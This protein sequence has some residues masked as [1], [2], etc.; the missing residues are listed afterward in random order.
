MT[1]PLARRP[2]LLIVLGFAL[3]VVA[4]GGFVVVAVKNEPETIKLEGKP[5]RK[6]GWRDLGIAT[7]VLGVCVAGCW[8]MVTYARKLDQDPD[9]ESEDV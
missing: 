9:D 5:A 3:F 6:F 4:L 2:W 8:G 1:N 7:G